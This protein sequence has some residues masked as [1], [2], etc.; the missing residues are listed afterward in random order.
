MKQLL[1]LFLALTTL[2][3]CKKSDPEPVATVQTKGFDIKYDQSKQLEIKLGNDILDPK[4]FVWKIDDET[5]GSVDNLGMFTAQK[6]GQATISISNPDGAK[7][8]ESVI[9][10]SPYSTLFNEP[11]TSWGTPLQSI[12][13]D[14]KRKL[15]D[16]QTYSLKFEGENMNVRAVAYELTSEQNLGFSILQL[17]DS[18]ATRNEV[19]TFLKERYQYIHDPNNVGDGESFVNYERNKLVTLIDDKF[20]GLSVIYTSYKEGL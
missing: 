3:A 7:V 12:I 19:M 1:L 14:E 17:K 15:I 9:T 2:G 8:S 16:R 11:I 6:V 5:V 10:V 20:L 4:S 13:K 18:P